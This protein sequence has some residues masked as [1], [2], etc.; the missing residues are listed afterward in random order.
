MEKAPREPHTHSL[1]HLRRAPTC[2]D[3]GLTSFCMQA[4]HSCI[5]SATA[6]SQQTDRLSQRNFGQL[7][8]IFFRVAMCKQD[9][10]YS[11]GACGYHLNLSSSQRL[12][13]SINRKALRKSSIP[14]LSIDESKIKQLDEF[15]CAPYVHANG[16]MGL[17][18]LRTRLLCGKCE[19]EIGHTHSSDRAS[20]EQIDS[21]DSSSSS[22]TSEH[23]RFCIKIKT[24]QPILDP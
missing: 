19:K 16:S 24:L 23:R 7:A 13:S 2:S 22:G 20:F 21:S 8:T 3:Q 15:I 9:V 5:S 18:K 14:F 1:T 4:Q 17:H 11:C 10:L 6:G 12:L